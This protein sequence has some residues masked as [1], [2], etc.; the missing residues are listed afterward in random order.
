MFQMK[1][2]FTI[3][4]LIPGC[5][6]FPALTQA[7]TLVKSQ[8]KKDGEILWLP[9]GKKGCAAL[10]NE[11]LYG[12]A[13]LF[14]PEIHFDENM[15]MIQQRGL[16]VSQFDK[17]KGQKLVYTVGGSKKT[18]EVDIQKSPIE[19]ITI[20]TTIENPR[21]LPRKFTNIYTL[22]I[23]GSSCKIHQSTS[24]KKIQPLI[25]D[26]ALCKFAEEEGLI[27][28]P[29]GIGK[30]EP[31]TLPSRKRA[32]FGSG[33]FG[34]KSKGG[35]FIQK[36]K[37]PPNSSVAVAKLR[38]NYEQTAIRVA[39][40]NPE[41]ARDTLRMLQMLKVNNCSPLSR[42]FGPR[43]AQLPLNVPQA[44]KDSNKPTIKASR[45]GTPRRSSTAQ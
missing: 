40:K 34:F 8:F 24:T 43:N 2:L 45:P 9:R 12:S 32:D 35:N 28:P 30:K 17:S 19:V 11:F 33:N 21:N 31:T 1:I 39:K 23:D 29:V 37:F 36:A 20:K 41:S 15:N 26:E 16:N 38:R 25:Y 4:F 6:F 18:V 27:M 10:A 3:F 7:E 44:Y 13:N 5:L 14:V 22:Y 42:G